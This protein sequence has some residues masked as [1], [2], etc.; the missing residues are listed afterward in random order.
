MSVE[1]WPVSFHSWEQKEAEAVGQRSLEDRRRV[2]GTR[3]A[4]EMCSRLG[5]RTEASRAGRALGEGEST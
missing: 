3:S 2:L 5:E 4:Q 1:T